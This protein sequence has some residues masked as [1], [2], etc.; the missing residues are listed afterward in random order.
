[1]KLSNCFQ[2]KS[3]FYVENGEVREASLAL[4]GHLVRYLFELIGLAGGAMDPYR[5]TRY[6]ERFRTLNSMDFEALNAS[7]RHNLAALK[8]LFYKGDDWK[9]FSEEILKEDYR[10]LYIKYRLCEV[11]V[12]GLP[13]LSAD[14]RNFPPELFSEGKQKASDQY[15]LE[16]AQEIY[17]YTPN[18]EEKG[19][20]EERISKFREYE[21]LT[22]ALGARRLVAIAYL[23]VMVEREK[24]TLDR[25]NAQPLI[26]LARTKF[27]ALVVK[28]KVKI[29][30][31]VGLQYF[32]LSGPKIG[33]QVLHLPCK[34]PF[35]LKETLEGVEMRYDLNLQRYEF[36]CDDPAIALKHK[37]YFW[38]IEERCK[39]WGY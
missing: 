17:R 7:K 32:T 6:S 34:T 10:A 18:D 16:C 38:L 30:N 20:I 5:W 35:E 22:E 3:Y 37:V 25:A 27:G 29:D 12:A 33:R 2:V 23:A 15:N 21:G 19:L 14:D 13:Y 24:I 1:M 28:S 31:V 36:S 9:E 39:A 26:Q 8:R 4:V 11:G